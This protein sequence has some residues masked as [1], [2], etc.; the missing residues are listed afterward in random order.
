MKTKLLEETF[1]HHV[2]R[3]GNVL[4][5]DRVAARLPGKLKNLI[6][7]QLLDATLQHPATHQKR[8][9]LHCA[10]CCTE[11]QNDYVDEPKIAEAVPHRNGKWEAMF[12]VFHHRL[13]FRFRVSSRCQIEL[14]APL[15]EL[16]YPRQG[17]RLKSLAARHRLQRLQ[18][19]VEGRKTPRFRLAFLLVAIHR[20]SP[21]VQ[22]GLRGRLEQV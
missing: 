15:D 9:Y 8:I 6:H 22:R 16:R 2:L 17:R 19:F 7:G 20:G 14:I 4:A 11:P 5:D 10:F 21:G 18:V 1:H 13:A 12:V 3:R